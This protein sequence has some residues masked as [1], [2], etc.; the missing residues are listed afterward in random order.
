MAQLS[1]VTRAQLDALLTESAPSS[2]SDTE[3]DEP[4][5]TLQEL[6]SDPGQLGLETLLQEVAKLRRIRQ[7][8]LPPTLFQQIPLRVLQRYRQ[9]AASESSSAL[10]DHPD[11]IRYTLLAVLCFLRSQE[12]TDNLVDL[13]LVLPADRK[14]GGVRSPA[15]G[16]WRPDRGHAQSGAPAH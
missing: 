5:S 8:Q 10:R 13:L 14:S 12:I 2:P 11:P 7:I 16:A 15:R 1:P 4:I 6:R 9:R 3:T